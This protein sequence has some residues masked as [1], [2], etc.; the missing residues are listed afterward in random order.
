MKK[1]VERLTCHDSL[2]IMWIWIK[3]NTIS[4]K[5]VTCISPWLKTYDALLSL[6]S[7]TGIPNSSLSQILGVEFVE[8]LLT[9]PQTQNGVIFYLDQELDDHIQ[10]FE[11]ES[12]QIGADTFLQSFLF[13]RQASITETFDQHSQEERYHFFD[14]YPKSDWPKNR[15]P[16]KPFHSGHAAWLA[17]NRQDLSFLDRAT[18]FSHGDE[19]G[20]DLIQIHNGETKHLN[21]IQ[22]WPTSLWLFNCGEH[23]G[24]HLKFIYNLI[25]KNKIKWG[26]T[27]NGKIN[28]EQTLILHENLSSAI[29][30][31]KSILKTLLQSKRELKEIRNIVAVGQIPSTSDN[32]LLI[33]F[34][35]KHTLLLLAQKT[36]FIHIIEELYLVF[37]IQEY[38]TKNE[39][40]LLLAIK[41]AYQSIP[42]ITQQVTV[43]PIAIY[44]AERSVHTEL[45]WFITNFK[46][47]NL[48]SQTD[49]LLG[50]AKGMIRVGKYI[51]A[52]KALSNIDL[53]DFD[54][55]LMLFLIC[56]DLHLIPYSAH[57]NRIL[58][59]YNNSGDLNIE[60]YNKWLGI[61]ATFAYEQGHTQLALNESI[62]KHQKAYS[63]FQNLVNYEVPE[64]IYYGSLLVN[65]KRGHSI[66]L[67]QYLQI[68]FQKLE[69]TN[70]LLES[71]GSKTGGS[72]TIKAL[73]LW[74][75]LNKDKQLQQ[76][77]Q[78]TLQ[79]V[80]SD[81]H[82]YSLDVGPLGMARAFLFLS[83]KSTVATDW[84]YC[85]YR[86]L[87]IDKQYLF[88]TAMLDFLFGLDEQAIE[89]LQQ[90]EQ[91]RQK[92][93]TELN[94]LSP[95][96]ADFLE[97]TTS[98]LEW[99]EKNKTLLIQERLN[100]LI[101][102][103][104]FPN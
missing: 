27:S 100:P 89:L 18:I 71:I 61:K 24:K 33:N 44:I 15:L 19:N 94:R 85:P 70:E 68:E 21:H 57:L 96:K 31:N 23:T 101:K 54:A 4:E 78:N 55:L 93:M 2:D 42:P 6:E 90:F 66:E 75:W 41:E 74:A 30:H 86:T 12:I 104:F 97:A 99:I 38:D 87:L 81:Y 14:L 56:N 47:S 51:A 43:L 34:F 49:A 9:L 35:N 67:T 80:E 79:R 92:A 5:H 77:I 11:W 83:E 10:L 46:P 45:E 37:E 63:N 3:P 1:S 88:E 17:I 50:V 103:G 76:K 48:I 52:I 39:K 62:L 82:V 16:P 73:S 32:N 13:I 22:N 98:P 65:N 91:I 29:K 58:N 8:E 26:L 20:S 59:L 60:Q 102:S 64:I 28:A 25:S 95:F 36:T 72:R 69:N 53:T 40:K 84:L 7:S